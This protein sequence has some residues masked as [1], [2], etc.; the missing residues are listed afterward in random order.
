VLNLGNEWF[1]TEY[2]PEGEKMSIEASLFPVSQVI[3]KIIR[4][5]G[6]TPLGFLLAIGHSNAE[7]VL[8]SLIS[9]L[10]NGEGD[11]AMI[12]E[13][14]DYDLDEAAVLYNAVEETAAM[15]AAG[16][17]PVV[18]DRLMREKR[19]RDHFKPFIHAEGE[20]TVPSGITI[21]GVT[22]GHGRW[23]TIRIP[24]AVLELPLEEQLATLPELMDHYRRKYNGA[25]PFF[26]K[27][28]GFRFVRYSDYYQFDA[29]GQL[30]GHVEEPF[31]HGEAWVELR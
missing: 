16:V 6:Y 11:V 28:V 2:A 15:K 13:I 22:G 14:A 24:E 7:S 29:A 25:C 19:E 8:P 5:S 1:F 27:L 4:N 26:G 31:R 17:D 9:W 10:E 30:Q 23:T 18:F 12:A 21:F 20:Q 3:A